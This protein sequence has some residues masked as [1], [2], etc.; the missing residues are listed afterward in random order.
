MDDMYYKH[1]ESTMIKHLFSFFA[2][3]V[4]F[5]SHV[6]EENLSREGDMD[7]IVF[8]AGC[9]WCVEAAYRLVEGVTAVQVGYAGGTTPNPTYRDV[10]SGSTGHAEVAAVQFDPE[11]VSLEQLL[12]VFMN[13]HDPTQLN[14]QG[15]DIGTQ[16]RS[17]VFYRSETQRAE[18]IRFL[19]N[20][21]SRYD[22][23]IVT[24]VSAL[25][26]FYVAEDYHQ[27]YF[28]NNPQAGY[29]KLVIAP[30]VNKVSRLLGSQT[31]N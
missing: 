1:E 6:D 5:M 10:C 17:A 19:E 12:N 3:P 28:D 25:E 8:G 7:S 4:L 23:P 2:I 24:D 15:A 9:F 16:Y 29:C 13:I 27:Q 20:A 30:K 18:V 31:G 11:R 21:Q 22:Q 26:S 14:R